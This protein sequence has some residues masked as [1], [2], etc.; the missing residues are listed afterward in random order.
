MLR[1]DRQPGT[2][3][4]RRVVVPAVHPTQPAQ[5]LEQRQQRARRTVDRARTHDTPGQAAVDLAKR[6][7]TWSILADA[8][9][10]VIPDDL[11]EQLAAAETAPGHFDALSRSTKR[12]ILEWI[13]KAKRPETRQRRI[14]QTVECTARNVA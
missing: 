6:T 11:R 10:G 14:A 5:R 12:A 3:S 4:R 8:Q 13:A 1:L 9:H 7:G 2:Q